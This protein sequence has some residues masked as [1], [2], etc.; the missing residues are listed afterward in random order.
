M[1]IPNA[2]SVVF[3]SVMLSSWRPLKEMFSLPWAVAYKHWSNIDRRK[4]E[5]RLY[6]RVFVCLDGIRLQN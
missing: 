3:S 5:S 1:R 4:S 2:L 6:G